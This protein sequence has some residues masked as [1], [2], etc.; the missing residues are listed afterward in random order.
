M[1]HVRQLNVDRIAELEAENIWLRAELGYREDCAWK[2]REAFQIRPAHAWVL[3]A[4]YAAKG[5]WVLRDCIE[6]WIPSPRA[7]R[8]FKTVAVYISLLRK[9]FGK[10]MIQCSGKGDA[11]AYR[12]L[13]PVIARIDAALKA[14]GPEVAP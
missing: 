7:E 14:L 5:R 4:L 2:I 1:T 9:T 11:C 10:D 6:A 13:P 8:H 12:I 3:S